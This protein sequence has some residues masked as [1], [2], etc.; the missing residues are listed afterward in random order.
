[1]KWPQKLVMGWQLFEIITTHK[2]S[3]RKVMFLQVSVI[4]F[5]GGAWCGGCLV[6]GGFL[7]LGGA[8]SWG[9]LVKGVWSWGVPG[10][11]P[12][13]RLLLRAVRILLECILVYIWIYREMPILPIF[14]KTRI[15]WRFS[16]INSRHSCVFNTDLTVRMA[17][18]PVTLLSDNASS[19]R[20]LTLFPELLSTSSSITPVLLCCAQRAHKPEH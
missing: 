3:C 13:R 10:G 2:R 8:C 6:P 19:P 16:C 18:P 20:S 5:R 15:A 7:A 14:E 12:P 17:D 9:C 1:M 11:D 4:P